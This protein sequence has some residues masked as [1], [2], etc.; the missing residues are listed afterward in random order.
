M[1]KRHAKPGAANDNAP[2]PERARALVLL[3]LH[4]RLEQVYPQS[5][6]AQDI[7]AL[8]DHLSSPHQHAALDSWWKGKAAPALVAVMTGTAPDPANDNLGPQTVS[9]G[10]SSSP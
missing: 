7:R 6:E 10:C 3:C 2:S 4:R 8:I 1:R 5:A 9:L